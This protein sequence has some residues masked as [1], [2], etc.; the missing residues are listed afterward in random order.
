MTIDQGDLIL[1]ILKGM[2]ADMASI[3][4]DLAF[5]AVR[6]SAL[7]DYVRGMTTSLFGLQADM[8]AINHRL[9]R[10]ERRLELSDEIH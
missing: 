6:I 8:T 2:Q 9:G 7:K 10:I 1:S 3:K 5:Q 4:R